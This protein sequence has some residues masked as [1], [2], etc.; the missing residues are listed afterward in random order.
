MHNNSNFFS[1]A[2]FVFK[3]KTNTLTSRR[4]PFVTGALEVR[5]LGGW[6]CGRETAGVMPSLLLV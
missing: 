1:Y 6:G 5:T 4:I 2:S 3:V